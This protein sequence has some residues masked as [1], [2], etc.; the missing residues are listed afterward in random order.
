MKKKILLSFLKLIVLIS[1]YMIEVMLISGILIALGLHFPELKV[2]QQVSFIQL[3]LS[4]LIGSVF[5]VYLVSK[6]SMSRLAVFLVMSF[7]LFFSNISVAIEG[8]IFTPDYVTSS[9]L[10]SLFVQQLFIAI[11][12][13]LTII[14]LFRKKLIESSAEPVTNIH[15][16]LAVKT[17]VGAAVYM[18]SY[19]VWGWLN[20]NLFTHSFYE[21][22]V[23]GLHIPEGAVLIKII[24]FRGVLVTLS[25]VPFLLKATPDNKRK[26]FETGSI[27]F[28]FGGIIPMIYTIGMLPGALIWYSL[29][30]IFLQN[31][32]SGMLIYKIFM[33]RQGAVTAD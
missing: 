27:L 11:A 6:Y 9:V 30:E 29:I 31:F 32:I 28:L 26:L 19:Y 15:K 23:S 13:S 14:L 17:L 25:V 7:I 24:L 5:A 4:G 10:L 1:A 16:S 3:I 20:Y 12:F 8:S 22:G 21:S 18:I 33:Y 2:S